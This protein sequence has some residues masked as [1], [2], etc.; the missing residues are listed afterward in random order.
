MK[1]LKSFLDKNWDFEKSQLH[2]ILKQELPDA[3]DEFIG[4][5]ADIAED[6][7]LKLRKDDGASGLLDRH[8]QPLKSPPAKAK[9]PRKPKLSDLTVQGEHV[10][11]SKEYSRK[12]GAFVDENEG[13]LHTNRGVFHINSVDR[14]TPQQDKK[15]SRDEYKNT[16]AKAMT[17]SRPS[18][19]RAMQNWVPLNKMFREGKISPELVSH[20]VLFALMSPGNPVAMQEHMYA[21]AVDAMH[22]HGL[23]SVTT[24][25]QWHKVGMDWLDRNWMP[26][27]QGRLPEHSRDHFEKLIANA[28]GGGVQGLYTNDGRVQSFGKPKQLNDYYM[29]YLADHHQRIMDAIRDTKGDGRHVARM[30]DEVNGIGPKLAR[31]TVGMMGGGNL[32]VPDTHF[33]R[34]TF[35]LLP[36]TEGHA[37][38]SSPDNATFEHIR[39]ATTD[40]KNANDAL[41]AIDRHYAAR[42]PAMKALLSDPKLGPYFRD[43]PEHALFPAFWWHWNSVAGHERLLGTPPAFAS[44]ANTDHA[45]FFQATSQFR[46]GEG[47]YDP[48]LP[49]RTAAQHH[50]WVRDFGAHKAWELYLEHLVPQLQANAALKSWVEKP[51]PA[52]APAQAAPD[53]SNVF[54]AEAL[55]LNLRK[56]F[57]DATGQGK[58]HPA[59]AEVAPHIHHTYRYIVGPDMKV[60]QHPAGRFMT[61]GGHLNVLEDYHGDLAHLTEGPMGEVQEQQLGALR[62]GHTHDVVPLS[63]IMSG[64]RPELWQPAQAKPEPKAKESSWDYT[65]QGQSQADHLQYRKGKAYLNGHPLSH[66]QIQAVLGHVQGG[67]ATLRYRQDRVAKMENAFEE[68]LKN[69]PAMADKVNSALSKL[70]QLVKAGHLDPH[71]AEALRQHAFM[72]PMTGHVLGNKFAYTDFLNRA[73]SRGG[74]HVALDGNDFK[75]VNDK[76]G[77]AAGDRA[78]Q[79]MGQA[80]H[81]ARNETTSLGKLFRPGGDEF[82]AWFPSHE[83]AATFARTLRAKLEAIPSI[84]GEHKLSM[85]IGL[86][87]TPEH[88][89]KALYEAKKQK[90][91]PEG[92]T[93]PDS[94]KWTSKYSPGSAPSF[95]HSLVPGSEGA[96]PLD[97]SQLQVKPPPM[98]K[99]PS[100]AGPTPAPAPATAPQQ[101]QL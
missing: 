11:L 67:R 16:F 57:V 71:H 98:P 75:S 63:D 95:A 100:A 14:P 88:A 41:E 87:H 55:L 62:N 99:N 21:H 27:E 52:P 13:A 20:S 28:N 70:D 59:L 78:I 74:V 46:K 25:D 7:K 80:L 9:S 48:T 38:G 33:L 23:D 29:G 86:G 50:L 1:T 17:D 76:Y 58:D 72:D 30:L 91:T 69:D 68:M 6:Y 26:G 22:A 81:E 49:I 90:Y 45:P 84:N 101:K 31:Y 79:A 89:D 51:A 43:N 61:A 83:H 12:T 47:K 94:R 93:N 37:P 66:E 8:G 18:H 53:A 32:V 24:P 60:H 10:P 35:G 36:D 42:H 97:H 4:H 77:H 3:S 15:W 5:F 40:S 56:A 44:N 96:I 19:Q 64:K 34:H 85:G 54:K 92:M 65:R 82:A 2:E 73:E 39:A